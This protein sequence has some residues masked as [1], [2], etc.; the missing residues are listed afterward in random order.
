[1]ELLI[2][3]M[4]PNKFHETQKRNK[5]VIKRIILNDFTFPLSIIDEDLKLQ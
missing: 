3:R 2:A 5:K 1:M 4:S